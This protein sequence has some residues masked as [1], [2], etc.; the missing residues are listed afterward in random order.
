[1]ACRYDWFVEAEA[2]D[3]SRASRVLD[4]GA[5]HPV[6]VLEGLDHGARSL[7]VRRPLQTGEVETSTWRFDGTTYVLDR[8]PSIGPPRRSTSFERR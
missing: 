6:G 8:A 5:G 4:A 3:Q 7:V 2:P 1:M